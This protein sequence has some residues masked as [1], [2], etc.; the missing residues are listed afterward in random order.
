MARI[1]VAFHSSEGQTA[2]VA[3]R[4]A[5]VLR[6]DG[7]DADVRAL[8]SAPAP[9][10]YDGVVLGDSIHVGRHSRPMPKYLERHAAPLRATRTALFQVSMSAAYPDDEHAAEAQRTL[11]QL[12]DDTGFDPDIVAVFAGAL[13]YTRYG[14]VKRHVMRSIERRQGGET[15]IS[16]D[17]EYTDW[18]AVEHFAH[19]VHAMVTAQQSERGPQRDD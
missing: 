1:L 5:Q 15:D 18:D 11:H 6:D 19:D 10:D 4:I 2:R 3:E 12:L 17:Y 9:D 7:D 8:A 13:V 14:W 16:R